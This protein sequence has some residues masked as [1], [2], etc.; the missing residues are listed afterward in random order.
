MTAMLLRRVRGRIRQSERDGLALRSS[1]CTTWPMLD[2]LQGVAAS[3]VSAVIFDMDGT[4]VDSE[5]LTEQVVR[6]LLQ[7]NALSVDEVDYAMCYG[8]TWSRIADMLCIRFRGLKRRGL[9]QGLSARFL[10]LSLRRPPSEIAGA[11]N[12]VRLAGARVKTAIATSSTRASVTEVS[13]RLGIVN[14]LTTVVSAEDY[15]NSKPAP[16]CYL[17]AA[18]RLG[19]EPQ[20]C[21][22][23]EDSIPGLQAARAAGMRVVAIT[24]R[25][26]DVTLAMSIADAAIQ[27]YEALPGTFWD[28]ISGAA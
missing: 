25:S 3:P 14:V 27:T 5:V 4:L 2:V 22:V 15:A 1:T 7:E 20:G 28:A 16:D 19:V 11:T 8:V 24:H 17:L 13:R 12:A 10:A 18:A 6:E 21:L 9:E 23:F 26:T